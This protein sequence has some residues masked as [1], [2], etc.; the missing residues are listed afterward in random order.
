MCG[1]EENDYQE[2]EKYAK[3]LNPSEK[4]LKLLFLIS[5]LTE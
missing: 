3:G 1:F 2:N 5:I 4:I